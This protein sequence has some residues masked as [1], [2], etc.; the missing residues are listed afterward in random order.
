LKDG[1]IIRQELSTSKN[2]EKML[3]LFI[4]KKIRLFISMNAEE[5]LFSF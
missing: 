1:A 3:R 4:D 5:F 2:S